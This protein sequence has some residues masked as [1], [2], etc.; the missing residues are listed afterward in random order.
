MRNL[1]FVQ[2]YFILVYISRKG[3][4]EYKELFK[5]KR[6]AVNLSID[7]HCEIKKRAAVHNQSIKEWIEE[8]IVDKINKEIELG[9][10]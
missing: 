5:E 2:K 3:N 8:A 6:L 9:F 4:V 7:M 10:K 1:I